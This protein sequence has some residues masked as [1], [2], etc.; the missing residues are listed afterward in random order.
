MPTLAAEQRIV[1]GAFEVGCT[2]N[3][4]SPYV[5]I[6]RTTFTE[7]LNTGSLPNDVAEKVLEILEVM[8]RLRY[9][10]GLPV[11]WSQVIVCRPVVEQMLVEFRGAKDPAPD[12]FYVLSM[13]GFAYFAGVRNGEATTTPSINKAAAWTDIQ[14]AGIAS[15]ELQFRFKTNSQTIPIPNHAIK[16]KRSSM[17]T[18]FEEVGLSGNPGCKQQ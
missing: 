16:R 7:K 2:I 5:G 6:H 15:C 17:V 3:E 10:A 11:D 8:K 14:Q 18:S 12:E 9:K 1:R 13:N 4:L